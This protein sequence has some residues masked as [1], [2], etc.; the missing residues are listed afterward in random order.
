MGCRALRPLQELARSAKIAARGAR[1][2]DEI[3]VPSD[4]EPLPPAE[5]GESAESAKSQIAA[6]S[7]SSS[8]DLLSQ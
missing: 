6:E 4:Q 5:S 7:V 2:T 8:E 1:L 3:E